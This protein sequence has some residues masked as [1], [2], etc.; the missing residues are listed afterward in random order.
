MATMEAFVQSSLLHPAGFSSTAAMPHINRLHEHYVRLPS[1]ATCEVLL[2]VHASSVNPCDV[3][4]RIARDDY[5]K[6]LGSDVAGV[7]L[8]VSTGC[9]RL[10]QGD[11]V[12]GD[13]GA[14]THTA[15][16]ATKELGA[17]ATYAVALEAQLAKIPK[18]MGFAEAGALP[19]VALTSY[20]AL[21][22]Y[23][24]A[25]AWPANASVLILGGSG[26]CGTTGIQLA[27]AF[28]ARR[29]AGTVHVTTTTSAA[30]TAYVTALGADRVIDY[31]A[32]DWWDK[33]VIADDSVDVV[34]DT[35]G[36]QGT[37]ARA[38]TKLKPGG[39]YVT[40]TGALAPSVRP[41]RHQVMF[42]NSDTNLAS[43]PLMDDLS[44][45]AASGKLRMPNVQSFGLSEVD[46]G[47]AAS[48][49]G[50]VVGKVGIRVRE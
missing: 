7:V 28:A 43:A 17:Y 4:P 1:N 24:N 31:H 14:N 35:V 22:W 27:K 42:I 21:E 16:G 47:F 50:H 10:E 40:I 32:H 38:M 25:A 37:G 20:K 12:W 3:H 33:D 15:A 11:R 19:K 48:R 5:P 36:Q 46:K 8:N 9:T 30:N 39:Y 2:E 23:A 18:S 44:A 6:V 29:T 13:I 49:G 41:G 45:I 34:Y 26:G